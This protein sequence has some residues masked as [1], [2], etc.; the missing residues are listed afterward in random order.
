MWKYL[1]SLRRRRLLASCA[2]KACGVF[3]THQTSVKKAKRFRRESLSR[4]GLLIKFLLLVGAGAI[5]IINWILSP[6]L[7][8]S[9]SINESLT[10]KQLKPSAKVSI[11]AHF[12]R[13]CSLLSLL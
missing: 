11:Y 2:I 4:A 3:F 5:V 10:C 12:S 13:R 8:A 7:P 1:C 6:S 9:D